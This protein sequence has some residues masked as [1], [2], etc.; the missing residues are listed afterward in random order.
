[1]AVKRILQILS[2]AGVLDGKCCTAYPAVKPA[3]TRAGGRWIDAN[4][5]FTNAVVDG[6]LVTA[7]AWPAHPEWIRKFLNVLGTRVEP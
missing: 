3:V 6:S 5:T 2:A 7:P 1:M 4:A